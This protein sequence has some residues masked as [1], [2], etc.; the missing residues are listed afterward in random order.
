MAAWEKRKP[1]SKTLKKHT[2]LEKKRSAVT[3]SERNGPDGCCRFEHQIRLRAGRIH[4]NG[5]AT[6]NATG[7]FHQHL[8]LTDVIVELHLRLLA[9]S[10]PECNSAGLTGRIWKCL[11]F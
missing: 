6:L 8:Q 11:I 1:Y 9:S 3:L 4:A 2:G 10:K 5:A 7:G